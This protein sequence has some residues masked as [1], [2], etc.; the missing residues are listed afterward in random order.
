VVIHQSTPNTTMSNVERQSLVKDGVEV[1][2]SD[3][4]LGRV[5]VGPLKN[6]EMSQASSDSVPTIPIPNLNI[7]IMVVGTH[8]DVLPFVGLALEMQKLGHRVRI[9]THA[10][11]RVLVVSK[12]VEFFPM[13]G[14]PKM[15]SSWMVETGGSIWG[16]ATHPKLIPD[17]TKMVLDILKSTWPAA[18]K[19]DPD[20]P[21]ATPFLADAII[22][23][24]PGIGHVHVAEALGIPCHIMFPQPWYYGTKEFPHPMAGLEYVQGRQRNMQSYG[25]FEALM[26]SN[27]S[28]EINSWRTRTL[29]VPRIYAYANSTNLVAAAK[30]PF[31]AMWSPAFVPKPDDWPDQCEV[32]GTFVTDQKKSFDVAPFA[33]IEKWLLAGPKPIFIGFGSM[34]I[35][36]TSRLEEIIKMAAH[37]TNLRII[38]QSS[39]SKLDVEDGSDLLR[40]IGPCPHDWLLPLC[41][42]VIHH[43]GAGTVAA[44]LRFGLPTFVCPFFADQFMWGFF[45]EMARVGP[46][47][48]PVNKLTDEILA[49]KLTALSSSDLQRAAKELSALMNQENGI[50]G[51]L[52]HWKDALWVDNMLCDVSLFLGETIMARYKLT[53]VHHGVKVSS[54]VAAL[55]RTQST[56]SAVKGLRTFAGLRETVL[57]PSGMERH[58]ITS[59][60]LT[61]FVQSF[62]HGVF[63]AI[64]GLITGTINAVYQVFVQS[65][66]FARSSG[67]FGCIFGFAISVFFVL[68]ELFKAI[69]VFFDRLLVAVTNGI[70]GK[71]YDYVLDRSWK[72]KVFKHRLI[73]AEV[74]TYMRQGIPK[75]RRRDLLKAFDFVAH[76]RMVFDS[77]KPQNPKSHSHFKVASL[78]KLQAAL[79]EPKNLI[80][81]KMT[82]REAK[83]VKEQLASL[84]TV[85]PAHLRRKRKIGSALRNLK[86]RIN[87]SGGLKA[88]DGRSKHGETEEDASALSASNDEGTDSQLEKSAGDTDTTSKGGLSKELSF[89]KWRSNPDETNV[90][91][92]MFI[93]TLRTVCASKAH[94]ATDMRT[95]TIMAKSRARIDIMDDYSEYLH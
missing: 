84:A 88:S 63:M 51:G 61:G 33:E 11:H 70:F 40:N 64:V 6:S 9:A 78:T 94:I 2:V 69:L 87:S 37:E 46:K 34:V 23:N 36:D 72:A 74:E 93:Q 85:P 12:G 66:R 4:E 50:M 67:A 28:G 77:A 71:N 82:S 32:V 68:A 95:S 59:H 58:S 92:S 3:L 39:W 57:N 19:P 26:W 25:I 56:W 14:D 18:T 17:K 31:S 81:L 60:N 7:C 10:T 35:Q 48:V 21:E 8:G 65:D 86:T 13:A 41:S 22:S 83:R 45:V 16:E 38:V 20:D 42:G 47:A 29:K 15:L 89:G 91:F 76:A 55:L 5:T 80:K 52:E 79:M 73:E 27:F 54:E 75:A 53:A 62:H 90:S 44:G 30:L 49:E 1:T 43:G 24:P